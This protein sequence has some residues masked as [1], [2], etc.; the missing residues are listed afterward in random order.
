MS[1]PRTNTTPLEQFAATLT[2]LNSRIKALEV[3]AHRHVN[4]FA[5]F[6]SLDDQTATINTPTPM[7]FGVTDLSYGIRLASSSL[8]EI[9]TPGTYVLHYSVQLHHRGGGGSGV[10][11]QTWLRY[12]GVDFPASAAIEHV[13]SN[14]YLFFSHSL[15]GQSQAPGDTVEIMWEVNNAQIVLEAEPGIAPIPAVPS[16]ICN[17]HRV[18]GLP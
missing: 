13:A 1:K 5:T 2:D 12:N 9:D 6:H 16:V 7:T 18:P 15:M 3:V 10:I 4:T 11:F 17:L 8:I 14:R